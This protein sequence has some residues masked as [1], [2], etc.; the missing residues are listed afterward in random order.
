M[1]DL[2]RFVVALATDPA[3]R[4][5]VRTDPR[6]ALD[7]S[8]DDAAGVTGEDVEAAAAWARTRLREADD[9]R[10]EVLR[11]A[12]PVRPLGDETPGDAA[13]RILGELCDALD[14][15]G[16]RPRLVALDGQAD[17]PPGPVAAGGGAPVP[18]APPALRGRRL[19]AVG[20]VGSPMDPEHPVHARPDLHAVHAP[21]GSGLAPLDVV[22]LRRGVPAAGVEPGAVATVVSVGS[23]GVEV[24]V[25]DEQ[26]GRRF[27]GVVDPDDVEPLRG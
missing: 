8:V 20:G 6:A 12:S 21:A 27:L 26:G 25:V 15:P 3:V 13:L 2:L 18:D 17:P 5:Q 19:W 10:A 16:E 9:P 7:A 14:D 22:R 24:E 4:E 1:A 23:A 11:A